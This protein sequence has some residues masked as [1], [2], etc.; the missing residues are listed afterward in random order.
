MERKRV[1]ERYTE[2][3]KKINIL[4]ANATLLIFYLTDL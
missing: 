2:V 1:G 4:V 3:D